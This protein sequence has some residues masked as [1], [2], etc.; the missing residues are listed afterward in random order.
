MA[1]MPRSIFGFVETNSESAFAASKQE[2][3]SIC[4]SGHR[5]QILDGEGPPVSEAWQ[6]A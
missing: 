4:G 1:K 6:E 2:A 3:L 5:Q